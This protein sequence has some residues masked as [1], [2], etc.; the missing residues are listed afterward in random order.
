MRQSAFVVIAAH[1]RRG[2]EHAHHAA[3]SS[4]ALGSSPPGRGARAL[5]H[6]AHT[7]ARLIPAG[8][9]ST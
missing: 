4:S 7:I 3:K 9:G 1:P 8:A 6:G 2:G 5:S